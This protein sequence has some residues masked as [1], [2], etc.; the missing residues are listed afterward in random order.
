[1]DFMIVNHI[2]TDSNE[3]ILINTLLSLLYLRYKNMLTIINTML[4]KRKIKLL[5]YILK[6]VAL[7]GEYDSI[8]ETFIHRISRV[9]IMSAIYE[10]KDK[11]L[12]VS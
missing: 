4:I 3:E 11:R 7:L 6:T 9:K 1:M 10:T 8:L 5:T 12:K 2:I